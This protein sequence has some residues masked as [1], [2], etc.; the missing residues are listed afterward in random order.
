MRFYDHKYECEK[1]N[2]NAKYLRSSAI[3]KVLCQTLFG[4]ITPSANFR[5]ISTRVASRKSLVP[6]QQ[7]DCET[8]WCFST[9]ST[10]GCAFWVFNTRH[11]VEG[12]G[13]LELGIGD[14]LKQLNN[15]TTKSDL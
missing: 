15:L 11:S 6:N 10:K 2:N 13:S 8:R 1:Q 4:A 7:Y 3:T 12:I 9:G 14:P 5:G